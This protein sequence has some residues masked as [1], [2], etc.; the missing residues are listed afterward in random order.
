MPNFRFS[1]FPAILIGLMGNVIEISIVIVIE[2]IHFRKIFH[3]ELQGDSNTKLDISNLVHVFDALKNC[4]DQLREEYERLAN[5]TNPRTEPKWH[6]PQPT[7]SSAEINFPKL[8]FKCPIDR[9]NLDVDLTATPDPRCLFSAHLSTDAGIEEVVVKFTSEYHQRAHEL[10]ASQTPPLAP[11]LYGCYDVVGVKGMKMI[12]TQRIKGKP[13]ESYKGK[14]P[15]LP[16]S[17]YTNIRKAIDILHSEDLVFGDLR[18]ANI[19]IDEETKQAFIIDFDWV[20]IHGQDTYPPF[21]NEDLISR[22]NRASEW[23]SDVCAQGVMKK[24]HD[25]WALEY[26]LKGL[27]NIV[28]T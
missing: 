8:E 3:L 26:V 6:L 9:D 1:K 19:M 18:A 13:M 28:E 7:S 25:K 5:E 12:V 17:V 4:A 15:K 11:K 16:S 20:G 24:E 22:G 27:C 23:H 21:I 2:Q 14:L 10:L